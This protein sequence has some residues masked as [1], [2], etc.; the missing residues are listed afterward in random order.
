MIT[1]KTHQLV[2]KF[3]SDIEYQSQADNARVQVAKIGLCTG[4]RGF[5]WQIGG[6]RPGDLFLLVGCQE[7]V[8]TA[9]LAFILH[10][11]CWK[12]RIPGQVYACAK[13]VERWLHYLLSAELKMSVSSLRWGV[14]E[15]DRERV[16]NAGH[17]LQMLP[18]L[19][20]DLNPATAQR[21]D[22]EA[23]AGQVLVVDDLP[24]EKMKDSEKFLQDLKQ[25][26]VQRQKIILVS[27][28]L[29]E[30]RCKYP[31]IYSNLRSIGL[32]G[33][34]CDFVG[35]LSSCVPGQ[36]YVIDATEETITPEFIPLGPSAQ[37]KLRLRMLYNARLPG[38]YATFLYNQFDVIDFRDEIKY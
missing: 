19:F 20:S 27:T 38:S 5:D 16:K 13:P 26:A 31:D 28:T 9:F 7:Q 25:V 1:Y 10:S 18:L 21:C 11:L 35:L 3:L 8:N 30:K 12:Q 33:H 29:D 6:L 34:I 15:N 2:D 37:D 24:L 32:L 23:S 17:I 4:L 14:D 36:D 22:F